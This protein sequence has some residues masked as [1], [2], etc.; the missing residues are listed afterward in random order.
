MRKS[1]HSVGTTQHRGSTAE[2]SV[3]ALCSAPPPPQRWLFLML[4]GVCMSR[5]AACSVSL[6]G[7]VPKRDHSA[8]SATLLLLTDAGLVAS[9][10]W[11]PISNQSDSNCSPSGIPAQRW[12]E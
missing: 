5:E 7:D 12:S 8:L 10:L 1:S 2:V 3:V 11:A 6:L 9:S 4:L